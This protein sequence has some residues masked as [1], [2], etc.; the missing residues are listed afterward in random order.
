LS[1]IFENVSTVVQH[2]QKNVAI[3]F[4]LIFYCGK[5][6]TFCISTVRMIGL[7]VGLIGL[8]VGVLIVYDVRYGCD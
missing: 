4:F 8:I 1:K 3:T 7:I 6:I 2:A 5:T